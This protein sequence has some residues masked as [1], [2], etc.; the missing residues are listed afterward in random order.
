MGKQITVSPLSAPH[1][2]EGEG[3]TTCD[4]APTGAP[5]GPLTPT[6]TAEAPKQQVLTVS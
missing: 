5:T 4:N 1:T 6:R 2:T 3:L